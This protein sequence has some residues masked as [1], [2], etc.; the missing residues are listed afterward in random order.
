[1]RD[2]VPRLANLG[3]RVDWHDYPM[4]HSVNAQEIADLAAWLGRRFA[5][6]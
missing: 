5:A 3:Y 4:P 2:S 6:K 1:M